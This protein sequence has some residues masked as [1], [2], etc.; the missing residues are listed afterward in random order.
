[1]SVFRRDL[2]TFQ[3]AAGCL[4]STTVGQMV[5]QMA[6]SSAVKKVHRLVPR[7]AEMT[8]FRRDLQTVQRSAGCLAS[9]T[10]TG[11][12]WRRG[13]VLFRVVALSLKTNSIPTNPATIW[14]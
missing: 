10:G 9:T 6:R 12:A 14:I 4:A 7:K 8:V 13:G 11:R 2:Q 5:L 3:R 1:M